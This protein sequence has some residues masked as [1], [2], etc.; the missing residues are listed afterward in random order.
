M[1]FFT[2]NLWNSVTDYKRYNITIILSSFL[3]CD[4]MIKIGFHSGTQIV[5][6]SSFSIFEVFFCKFLSLL[7]FFFLYLYY[8]YMFNFCL[9]DYFLSNWFI[10]CLYGGFF[11]VY[12]FFSGSFFSPGVYNFSICM[13]IFCLYVY[14]LSAC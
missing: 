9:Y 14:F 13:F 5:Y 10:F 3:Y 2:I 1:I 6:P 12:M 4:N 7:S 8:L 11:S